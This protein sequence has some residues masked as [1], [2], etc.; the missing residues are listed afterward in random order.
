M[1][2]QKQAVDRLDVSAQILNFEPG[3]YSVEV[4]AE[5][6][7][8][9]ASGMLVPCIRLD[10]L[11]GDEGPRAFVSALSGSCLIDPEA[12][13]AYLRVAGGTA[14]VLLTIYKLANGMAAPE[15]RICLLQA[16]SARVEETK[17]AAVL[18][19]EPLKLM[20][21][22]ERSGDITVS[23]GT[24]A[25]QPGGRGALEGFAVTPSGGILPEDIEYQAVLGSDWT[26]P[27]LT[28]GEFCGSRGL[29]LPLLGVRI[30]LRGEAAKIYQCSY[31]GSFVGVGEIGPA[32]DGAVCAS[33]GAI[34]ETLRIVVSRRAAIPQVRAVAPAPRVEE[35]VQKAKLR[36]A[37]DKDAPAAAKALAK[38]PKPA[39][40]TKGLSSI[41]ASLGRK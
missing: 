35:A 33:G 30:R 11:S 40:A 32:L 37:A 21:H 1:A 15:L 4:L 24:W 36:V 5:K 2:G 16:K 3:L 28:G 7:V 29:S 31:W 13:L 22:I 18:P 34:M 27:W 9:G 14:T 23:G 17:A 39:M 20:A 6:T 25:G 41:R 26:T 8:R 19:S 12:P 38:P 10:P